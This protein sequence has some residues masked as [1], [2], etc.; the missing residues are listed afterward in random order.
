MYREHIM[1][2][3]WRLTSWAF[4][5]KISNIWQ[6]KIY[7]LSTILKISKFMC[8]TSLNAE[9]HQIL[10]KHQQSWTSVFLPT[11][12]ESVEST[13]QMHGKE[14]RLWFDPTSK[15][16]RWRDKTANFNRQPIWIKRHFKIGDGHLTIINRQLHVTSQR[17][18][19]N[20]LLTQC[21]RSFVIP[22]KY[23]LWSPCRSYNTGNLDT[24][25]KQLLSL[26]DR[27]EMEDAV[28]LLRQSVMKG[29]VPHSTVVLNLQQQLGNLG[30]VE[31]LLELHEFLKVGYIYFIFSLVHC[32]LY[33][34]S[35]S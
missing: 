24:V 5:W 8:H 9:Y 30:E 26:M 18:S 7:S 19:L 16:S 14:N 4:P 21:S 12:C 34:N 28:F 1:S 13:T 32:S 11:A 27:W 25:E 15:E 23:M 3:I 6:E 20:S 31:C 29:V 10:P 33:L 35:I 17:C 2:R 22:P